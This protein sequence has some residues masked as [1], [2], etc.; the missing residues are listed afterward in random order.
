MSQMKA[1][2]DGKIHQIDSHPRRKHQDLT[3]RAAPSLARPAPKA[4]TDRAHI[5]QWEENEELELSEG[6]TSRR[7]LASAPHLLTTQ[8]SRCRVRLSRSLAPMGLPART[9]T[10]CPMS[11]RRPSARTLSSTNSPTPPHTHEAEN[12]I[13]ANTRTGTSTPAWPRT[14]A[15]RTP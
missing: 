7:L 5:S 12:R 10:P 11:S 3:A 4:C 6:A 14:S 2:N 8:L 13:W 9:P 15:S 1:F